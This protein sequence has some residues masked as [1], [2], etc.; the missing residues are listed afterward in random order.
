MHLHKQKF[1]EAPNELQAFNFVIIFMMFISF[2]QVWEGHIEDPRQWVDLLPVWA[3]PHHP[4]CGDQNTGD[5]AQDL[6]H[7]RISDLLD[8]PY[9]L[10]P[11]HRYLIRPAKPNYVI[12][13]AVFVCTYATR[14]A[15]DTTI[16]R[17]V[18]LLT[19]GG[20]HRNCIR[21]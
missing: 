9:S 17:V 14:L 21:S 19:G 1:S 7:H 15:H 20:I 5:R 18:S 16:W 11:L 12:F 4:A 2:S 10:L 6:N 3:G 8:H 13:E